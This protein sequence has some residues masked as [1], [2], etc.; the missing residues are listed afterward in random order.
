M[1]LKKS[2]LTAV[3]LLSSLNILAD[4]R[5]GD[6]GEFD[7]WDRDERRDR[8]TLELD[9]RQYFEGRRSLEILND[10][11]TKIRIGRSKIREIQIVMAT[12]AGRGQARLLVN[13]RQLENSV[14]VA[15]DLSSYR[16][17]VD[18]FNNDLG[19]EVRSLL[20][21][22]QG[23]FYV[24]RVVF[25]LEK[26]RGPIDPFP[27]PSRTE[28]LRQQI[29]QTFEREGGLNLFRQFALHQ[30]TGKTI[31]SISI[32]AMSNR[33]SYGTAMLLENNQSY[34][35][36]QMLGQSPSR[37]HF[38]LRESRGIIGHDLQSLRLQFNGSV[39]V[40]EI[41]IELSEDGFDDGDLGD[42]IGFPGGIN[43]PLPGDIIRPR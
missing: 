33:G 19:R 40:L 12:E 8:E 11:Y 29:N 36:S 15:R 41:V 24:D 26:N 10:P 16:F 39:T 22:M 35:Q 37:I 17:R 5:R 25:V 42:E 27:G 34:G 9:V 3:L 20:L 2:L 1:G 30:R 38:D 14:I 13:N 43:D 32:V 28:L 31:K 18:S 7:P 4:S 6:R 21:E 23:R